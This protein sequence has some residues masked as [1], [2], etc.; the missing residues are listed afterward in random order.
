LI[1]AGVY[2]DAKPTAPLPYLP[3]TP[4]IG[5]DIEVVFAT[6]TVA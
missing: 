2:R 6:L 4:D 3:G 1:D 5:A